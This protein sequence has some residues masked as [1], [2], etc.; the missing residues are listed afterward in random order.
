VF[1]KALETTE[2]TLDLVTPHYLD[3]NYAKI[4]SLKQ[5]AATAVINSGL[6]ADENRLRR[7]ETSA[8]AKLYAAVQKE[9]LA[10]VGPIVELP[11]VE[12]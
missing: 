3:E 11:A 7:R 10:I 4:L 9:K 5:T 2:E 1:V 12:K 6:K 8:L